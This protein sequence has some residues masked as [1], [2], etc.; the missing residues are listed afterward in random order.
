[1]KA[2]PAMMLKPGRAA[3]YIGSSMFCIAL[4]LSLA[5]SFLL[6]TIVTMEANLNKSIVFIAASQS[7]TGFPVVAAFLT[8]LK[9][10]NTDVGRL[11]FAS[12][13][14]ADLIDIVVAAISLTLGDVVSHP[15]APVRAVLSNIA[16]VIVI[17]FIIKP[18]VMWMMGPIKEMKLVSEKCI[19][20][21]TVVTLLLA[22]VS[23]IVGQHYVLGPLIFG[24]VLPIGPPFGATLV[25]KLST[26]VCG[27]LYPAYLAVTGLQTNIFKV[28][29]QSAIIVGIVMVSGIIIK[30]GAVI[31]P[32][33]HSQ[34]PVRD[35][36]LLAI[37]L[38]IKGIV[39]INVYNFW[40]D[41][42]VWLI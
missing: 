42:K 14:F 8:E 11:A 22:F 10:Q 16:F 41:N 1:V 7:F 15:L 30:L 23:E 18:M 37:I 24:L 32:A 36:F 19:F 39:E 21:T 35:A 31:L 34:V 26:L 4:F 6:K 33:L 5:P 38:N 20:I 40:K 2:D 25:S 12:A 13:V 9:I 27:L 17:V 29:F 3:M 28:D